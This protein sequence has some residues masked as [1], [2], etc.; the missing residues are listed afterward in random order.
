MAE[1]P[2][3]DHLKACKLLKKLQGDTSVHGQGT[4]KTHDFA[5]RTASILE[6]EN[7][8]VNVIAIA[9]WMAPKEVGMQWEREIVGALE[10]AFRVR[11]NKDLIANQTDLASSNDRLGKKMLF[12]AWVGV[13]VAI[14]GAG[15]ALLPLFGK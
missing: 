8:S 6:A 1:T 3:D 7:P 5:L 13:A 12:V 9:G 4:H 2:Q 15:A 10:D 14:V 11:L